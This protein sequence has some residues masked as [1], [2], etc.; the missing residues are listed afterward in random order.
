MTKKRRRPQKKICPPPLQEYYLQFFFMTSHLTSHRTTDIKP[1]MLPRVQ[2]G[3][4]TPHDR[5]DICGIA[6]V[7]T[8]GKDDIFMQRRLCKALHIYG[9]GGEGLVH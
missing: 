7:R 4:G 6:H 2:T 3:N 8:N 1:E 9:S 5:Y